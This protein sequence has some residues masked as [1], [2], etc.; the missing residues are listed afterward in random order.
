MRTVLLT[1][2]I[3]DSGP[4][5]LREKGFEVIE[6]W[7]LSEEQLKG[8]AE[9]VEA[10]LVRTNRISSEQIL[11]M[12]NL[13]IISKHGV[14]CDTIDVAC[15]RSRNITVAIASDANA[16]SVVE[17]TF[18]FMLNMA[19]NSVYMDQVVR[20]DYSQRTNIKAFDLGARTLLVLGYGRIGTRV[21]R[22]ASSFGMTVLVCDEKFDLGVSEVDGFEIIHDLDEGLARST[23]LTIHIPLTDKSANLIDK[24]RLLKMPKGSYLV[25][26]ARGGIVDEQALTEL[27]HSGH[28][29]AS[30][31]DVFSVE[32]ITADNPLLSAKNTQLSPHAAAFTAESLRR[33]SVAGD[34]EKEHQSSLRTIR[35]V[36]PWTLPPSSSQVSAVWVVLGP[37]KHTSGQAVESTWPSS[38]PMNGVLRPG[39][40][41]TSYDL[42]TPSTRSGVQHCHRW[43]NSACEDCHP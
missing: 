3:D 16:Q 24:D 1:E 19:K 31:F 25:N 42:A 27:T 20:S 7:T 22:L 10:I 36:P 17:H 38:M 9:T 4:A 43:L 29:S 40:G 12:P 35:Q 41:S 23:F 15:A 26:C 39:K 13:K 6:G 37:N 21:S 34:I 33:M 5:L 11:S 14:G 2:K 30:A 18:M 32:P 28:I 8:R